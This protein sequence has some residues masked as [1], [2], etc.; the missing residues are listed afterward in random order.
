MIFP[1]SPHSLDADRIACLPLC[2]RVVVSAPDWKRPLE[3]L[4]AADVSYLPFAADTQLYPLPTNARPPAAA[5][6]WELGFVGTWRPEREALLEGLAEFRVRVWGGPYWRSR[7][8]P[9]SLARKQWAGEELVG[10]GIVDVSGRTPIMLNILDA[11]TWPGPNMR[12]F[13]LP[14]CKAFVLSTRSPAIL[15][16]FDEGRTIECFDSAA[17]AADKARFYLSKPDARARIAAAAYEHVVAGGHTYVDRA[18][19]ILA[20]ESRDR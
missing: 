7:T 2:D 15:D 6:E 5:P 20:W 3:A 10:S 13:E 11:I 1:D 8:Q 17:E 4:G 9:G 16:I 12:S 18:R 14:A 19:T